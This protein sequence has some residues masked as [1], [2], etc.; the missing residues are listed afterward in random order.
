MYNNV[1]EFKA[2]SLA[3]L[4]LFNSRVRTSMIFLFFTIIDT[5]APVSTVICIMM[6]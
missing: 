1:L 5:M 4:T 6:Y 3:S 2:I